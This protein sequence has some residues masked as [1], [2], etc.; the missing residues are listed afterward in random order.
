MKAMY[1]RSLVFVLWA[2]QVATADPG[3]D[4]FESKIRPVLATKCLACHNGQLKAPFGGLRLDSRA[5]ILKGGDSGPAL[6]VGKPEESLLFKALSYTNRKLQMPPTGKLSQEVVDNFRHWIAIGAP[7]PRTEQ[8]PSSTRLTTTKS[9]AFAAPAKVAPATVKDTQWPRTDL[10]RF[11][12][13]NLE[14]K[15]LRPAPSIARREWIRRLTFDLTGLPPTPAEVQQYLDDKTSNADERLVDRLLASP[16]YGERWARHW[17]DLVRFSETN[18]HEFDNEKNDAWRYRD[19]LTRAFNQ[20]LHYNQLLREH[21]AGDLLK[22]SRISLDGSFHES[23]IATNFFWF[24]EVLNSATDSGKTRADRVDNQIDVFSK[25]VL[26]LTVSCARCHDHKFDPIPTKDYYALAGIMHNTYLREAVIDSPARQAEIAAARLEISKRQQEPLP[27]GGITQLRPSDS[28]FSDFD[29]TKDWHRE[30]QAFAVGP[31]HSVLSSRGEGTMALVGSLTSQKFKM[32]KMYVHIRLAGTAPNK[33]LYSGGDL[34]VTLVAD[35]HKSAHFYATPQWA[36]KTIRMTKEIGRECYFEIVDRSRDGFIAVDQIVLS[37]EETPPLIE[38]GS[39]PT[40]FTEPEVIVPPSSFA[41]VSFDEAA[42]NTRLHIRGSHENLGEEVP[43]GFLKVIPAATRSIDLGSGREELAD[44]LASPQN[45]LTARV[46]VN[47]IW[48]HHFGQGLVRSVDNFGRMGEAPTNQPLLDTLAVQFMEQGWS[49]KR[50]HKHLLLS[51]AY[52]MG[53]QAS[54][55]ALRL[56]PKNELFGRIPPR[57]LD[58][59]S[60]RDAMLAVSGSLDKNL[61]G[62]SIVPHISPYQEG[63]GKP[64]SG[65]LD[66]KN[67]RSLY[68][69]VRRNF[70]SPL[71]LAFDY[72]LPISTM[73]A[74]SSSTVPSQALLL[75]NNEFVHLQAQ[76]WASASAAQSDR[77]GWLYETAFSRPPSAPERNL[78]DDYLKTHDWASYCH[79][80]LNTAEFLYVQ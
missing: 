53:N 70:L 19:Y 3:E 17:L 48:Q 69:Q 21:I 52:R 58:A 29:H 8:A 31:R 63:R 36:W 80:L 71:F 5:A 61:Y 78:A 60:I 10:D 37:D 33:T 26:G 75:L 73:G 12:L 49:L 72:P 45:P 55:E 20:D 43:R 25:A 23:P 35:D 15:G 66:G 11:L 34:R 39:M 79:V 46:I 51:A 68:T 57:R 9:W 76:R 22:P 47:R 54:S 13:A 50:L 24:G 74:R 38:G 27:Q 40:S 77:I 4:F 6:V 30:G 16:H 65:P 1:F 7:D 41:M 64:L 62:P 14:A 59:E 18:G 2:L 56:D 28:M 32:P 44:W 42:R 67:R